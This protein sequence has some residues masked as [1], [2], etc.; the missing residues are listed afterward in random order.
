MADNE[1]TEYV[2]AALPGDYAWLFGER[3]VDA[4]GDHAA[5]VRTP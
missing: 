2:T 5:A 1:Y 4:H 3:P